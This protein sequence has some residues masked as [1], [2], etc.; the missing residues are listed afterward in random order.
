MKLRYKVRRRRRIITCCGIIA[1]VIVVSTLIITIK[2]SFK[3]SRQSSNSNVTY[4]KENVQSVYSD[5]FIALFEDIQKQ[6]YL[7]EEGIPYHSIETLLVEAPDYGH[8]TTSEAMSYMVWLGATY[9]KLTG[10]W[11]YFK[12]AW[13][14]TEQYIIPDPERDQPGVN[15][16]IPT[17]P[18]QYAPEADSPEKYPTPGDINAPTGI[19]PIADEL[20]S[21]Y[22]TKAIYQMHWLLDVDNW[23]GYGNHG[24]GTSR[25]SYINTYQRGSGESVWE[26]IPHPSWEDFRWGQ[27]NNGGFLKLFGNFGEPVRQWRYTSASDADARQIQ[28]TYW[29]YLWSKEQGK[30]KELQPYFEKAAKMGDYLRYTFFDKYFRPIGVQDSGRAGTGYDSCHYLLSWYAS[31]GGDINGTWS[32]RIGSSHCHQGYQNPMAAYALAK[33]SIFTPKSKNAKKDWEQSLDRQIEL[34]L[35]LQSAEGAIA[36]GVTNS[37]SGAYGKYPEGT[38][39][40]YDMAYDPHPVYNDPPS[41][42]WF[43]FQAWSMERIMEYY[44][45]TGDSRVKELCKKWVSW[46]I[47]NTRLKSDGTYEIPSTLEWSGQPDPWTGKPSENKNLH[48]TVTEWTVDVGVTA[49][50]AKALI[51]YA[52]ATEKHEKKI[53]DKARETAKQL[54]DR[55]WHNYRDKK[56]V[57]AKEPR[58]DYK[59]FF[60]EVYIPHDFS[61]I[62]AQGAEI[63]NGITFID[64]RPKYKEDK[65]YKMVEEAIKSGKD[66]V[67]T[68]HRYWAQAEVAMAN[69]MYHIFFEQ[70]KDGLVPGINS[71]D[72]NSS[73]ETQKS[74]TPDYTPDSLSTSDATI[75]ESP[76]N[77]NSPD[78]N[79]SPQNTSAPT[80]VPLNPANTPYNSSNAA[81]NSPNTPARP[82]NTTAGSPAGNNTVGRLILQYANGNGSDTTNTINPR[83]KLINNSGSPVKLSDVKIRYYYTIDGEKGQ[84]FWCDWS[85]AGNSNVT[86]KF[87]KLTSPKNNADYYLEI[88]F[89]EGAG[90]IEPGM[91]VEVQARF[92]KDDWSN[93]SQ[94]NDYSFSASAN[95]YGNS[96]HI[97]LYISGR[98]V[99]GNEP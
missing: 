22:G 95:D 42:R 87:V 74:E 91:S 18:A 90:S 2:N 50:Y 8:L 58:A 10:D 14:K 88:G 23:Y 81:P 86:G 35:Y 59:R 24:D 78:E 53:D 17:Q 20:A 57:A 33:E 70:K 68:Y 28:A 79:P 34:F 4:S 44:Y 99:S 21:T 36:G 32:W 69:A 66:P 71:D 77:T 76:A 93:Y 73:S 38:S 11:T 82:S 80:N 48:C 41:N 26:T 83:F 64:L 27:V 51:Y 19:D 49:S 30:E 5:R 46:A 98:L 52:A 97:A 92:S 96:N 40:F 94:A 63:K 7:S 61:G 16:Y 39:T 43:G 6:G 29:A 56:G 54:L 55:M 13:D 31:W 15:S 60:D 65:D 3:P 85:S 84:Q 47:E 25:C 89:T 72:S 45:L 67:M 62:N 1:A 75:T 12:D 37:W 9:G